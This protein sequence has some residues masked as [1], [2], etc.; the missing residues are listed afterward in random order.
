[1]A[2]NLIIT[3]KYS[4]CW[5]LLLLQHSRYHLLSLFH[6]RKRCFALIG[7]PQQIFSFHFFFKIDFIIIHRQSMILRPSLQIWTQWVDPYLSQLSCSIRALH[8]CPTESSLAQ[9]QH[10]VIVSAFCSRQQE[11]EMECHSF[12]VV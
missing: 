11:S 12:I 7:C 6:L 4:L 3:W 10:L 9:L 5:Q 8:G 1:M 2:H